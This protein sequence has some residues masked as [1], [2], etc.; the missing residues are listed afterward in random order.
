MIERDCSWKEVMKLLL[1]EGMK[2]GARTFRAIR[3]Q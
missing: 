2:D 3:P 1:F